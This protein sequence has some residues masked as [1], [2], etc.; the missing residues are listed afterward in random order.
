MILDESLHYLAEK[1]SQLGYN[2]FDEDD[3]FYN[4]ICTKFTTDNGTDILLSDRKKDIFSQTLNISIC[5]IGC[6]LESYNSTSKKAKCNCEISTDSVSTITS[7]NVDNLFNKKSIT[8]N[9][10]STLANS[11]F[12]VLKCVKLAFDPSNFSKNYGKIFMTILLIL[13][14]ISMI[15]YFIKGSA[16]IN[17]LLSAILKLSKE[18]NNNEKKKMRI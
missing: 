5:Q 17:E 1:A 12:R 7:L 15:I 9:F 6:E 16:R 14:G 11:N 4:N 8:E 3:A 18:N 10:Y 13:F 2:I